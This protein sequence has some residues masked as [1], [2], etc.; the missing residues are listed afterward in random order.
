MVRTSIDSVRLII[1]LDSLTDEE[2]FNFITD[3]SAYVDDYLSSDPDVTTAQLTR[4]EKWL[5]AHFASMKEPRIRRGRV[6]DSEF[7]YEGD[8]QGMFLESTRYGQMAIL[9]DPTGILKEKSS[10]TINPT[11]VTVN[12]QKSTDV[13]PWW[14]G[15]CE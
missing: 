3:A 11:V 15:V 10:G 9:F 7:S 12:D 2:V 13:D 1:D 5:A 8:F 6:G 14:D 4:V